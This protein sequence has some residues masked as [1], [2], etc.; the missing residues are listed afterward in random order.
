M[1]ELSPNGKKDKD[2]HCISDEKILMIQAEHAKRK[3][4]RIAKMIE[5]EI[6]S[7]RTASKTVPTSPKASERKKRTREGPSGD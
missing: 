3:Y 7:S 1:T 2:V 6:S 5:S 4:A